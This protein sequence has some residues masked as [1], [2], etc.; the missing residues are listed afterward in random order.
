MNGC[1]CEKFSPLRRA[2]SHKTERRAWKNSVEA[3]QTR[4][5]LRLFRNEGFGGPPLQRERAQSSEDLLV[6]S[7][8]TAVAE[9][10]DDIIV[11]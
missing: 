8:E 3:V 10:D 1:A 4:G 2:R 9:N 5:M 7:L 11:L 6:D